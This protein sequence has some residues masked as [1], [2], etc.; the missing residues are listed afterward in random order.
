MRKPMRLNFR[1]LVHRS[2]EGTIL[3]H[4]LD[5]DLI[6]SGHTIRQAVD[7]LLDAIKIQFEAS[8]EFGNLANFFRSA[9]SEYI[10]MFARGASLADVEC[11]PKLEPLQSAEDPETTLKIESFDCRE[12]E[13][14]DLA[15]A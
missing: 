6:G 13:D 8:I 5:L 7:S 4:C 1:V 14:S 10:E 2:D 11:R 3:A 9:D 15:M 12:Y